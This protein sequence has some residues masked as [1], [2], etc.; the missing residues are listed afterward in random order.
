MEATK[1]TETVGGISALDWHDR[2]ACAGMG[3]D[4]FFGS[5]SRC[6]QWK[7]VCGSC[8]VVDVCFWS[9]MA[10]ERGTGERFGVCGGTTATTRTRVGLVVGQGLAGERL[11]HAR[12]A[13]ALE[14]AEAVRL[15][16]AARAQEAQA[17]DIAR[18]ANAGGQNPAEAEGGRRAAGGQRHL[19]GLQRIW[20]EKNPAPG[21]RRCS[22]CPEATAVKSISEF[23]VKD[24]QGHRHS[25]CRDCKRKYNRE[26]MRRVNARQRQARQRAVA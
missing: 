5:T 6:C 10:A 13:G 9:A 2:A 24:K 1:T 3:I 7:T 4:I 20:L 17:S 12:L 26:R 11:I 15:A 21:M 22:A 25:L 16:E 18:L 14:A 23:E 8:P 19:V